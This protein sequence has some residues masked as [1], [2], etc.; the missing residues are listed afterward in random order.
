MKLA[1]TRGKEGVCSGV[2]VGLTSL[3][4]VGSEPVD[5]VGRGVFGAFN[6]SEGFLLQSCKIV[7]RLTCNNTNI[8]AK[9]RHHCI[10]LP[11][12][13]KM[14][15]NMLPMHV[16]ESFAAC[17]VDSITLD[18]ASPRFPTTYSSRSPTPF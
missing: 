15:W 1:R 5:G 18:A 16:K 12:P 13:L 3:I 11:I 4:G 2:D 6:N 9:T 17:P 10:V 8:V 14:P 7:E